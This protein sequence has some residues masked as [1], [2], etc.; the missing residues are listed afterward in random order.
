LDATF[1]ARWH[2]AAQR[3]DPEAID[4]LAR[5]VL[6][7]LYRFCLYRVGC[8]RHRCEEVVQETLVIAIQRMDQ[9]DPARADG[10][11]LP[12]LTGLARNEIRRVL[13]RENATTSLE[14]IWQHLDEQ[15]RDVYTQL[16]SEPFDDELLRREE[17]REMVG[18]TM[19]QLPPHYR[20]ALEAKYVA[21]R[22]VRDIATAWRTTEKAV[23]SQLARARKAFRATFMALAQN[24]GLEQG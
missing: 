6:P 22:S 16:E 11:I 9:Y 1:D 8:D 21:D 20:D 4:R 5:E 13:A 3:G 18:A 7:P 23:E 24:L 15:L 14:S 17:T 10:N 2:R 19:A 12:W